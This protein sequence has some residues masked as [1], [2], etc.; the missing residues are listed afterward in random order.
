M[1]SRC[2]VELLEVWRMT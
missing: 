1:K 2:T